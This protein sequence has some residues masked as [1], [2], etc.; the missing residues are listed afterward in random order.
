MVF[1]FLG[2]LLSLR[3]PSMVATGSEFSTDW[4]VSVS[5]VLD[6]P[7]FVSVKSAEMDV[8]LGECDLGRS[9]M[10][11]TDILDS[12]SLNKARASPIMSGQ[13]FGF[14]MSSSSS[15]SSLPISIWLPSSWITGHRFTVTGDFST[16]GDCCAGHSPAW[17]VIGHFEPEAGLL[18]TIAVSRNFLSLLVC[19]LLFSFGTSWVLLCCLIRLILKS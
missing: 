2:F 11:E 4:A 14:S 6:E 19:S 16:V 7:L 9:L 18:N 8:T 3:N 5:A 12:F 13:T 17:P 1:D 15:T 10:A